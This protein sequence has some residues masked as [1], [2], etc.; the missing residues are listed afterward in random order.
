[1]PDALLFDFDGVVIDSEPIHLRCFR[2]VLSKRGI[3]LTDEAYYAKYVGFDDHDCFAAVFADNGRTAGEDEI[4][5]MTDEKSALVQAALSG[6]VEPLAGTIELMRAAREAR[7]PAAICSGALRE[8]IELAG[9]AVGAID[10]VDVLVAAR[11]VARGKPDPQGYLLAMKLLAEKHS[12][13][14]DPARSWVFED[15]PQGIAAGKAAG[16]KVL[17]VMTSYGADELAAADR[18]VKSLDEVDLKDL[19]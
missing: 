12:R 5:V 4:A 1:M 9:R 16:C 10:L 15:T 17:A 7:V 11:D 3:A 2:E 19:E 18:V 14:I 8:E 13:E 6:P